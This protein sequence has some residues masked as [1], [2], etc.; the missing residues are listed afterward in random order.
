MFGV[1]GLQL[2]S[3]VYKLSMCIY[4]WQLKTEVL[5][6][7][8]TLPVMAHLANPFQT[9]L[10]R[11][12]RSRLKKVEQL[13]I[14]M[15]PALFYENQVWNGFQKHCLFVSATC[16]KPGFWISWWRMVFHFFHKTRSSSNSVW[17]AP[18]GLF[19]SRTLKWLSYELD[20]Y[21]EL[22]ISW[23]YFSFLL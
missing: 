4:L 22:R 15:K 11:S 17:M 10:P 9:C 14:L 23:I 1:G 12:L 8:S 13:D 2:F 21:I 5:V 19:D 3:D 18:Q 20:S 6:L 16:L 7:A